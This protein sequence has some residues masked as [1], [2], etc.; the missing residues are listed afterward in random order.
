MAV[1]HEEARAAEAG[2]WKELYQQ[3]RRRLAMLWKAFEDAEA[4]IASLERQ[5]AERA[6]QVIEVPSREPA[7]APAEEGLQPQPRYPIAVDK[8]AKVPGIGKGDLEKLRTYGVN[9]TD[10]LLHADL[11]RLA[12]ATGIPPER[13][14]TWRDT[15]ELIALKGLGPTWAARLVDA[16]VTSIPQ[17]AAMTPEELQDV[18]LK[19]YEQQGASED[20]MVLMRRTL[21]SRCRALVEAARKAARAL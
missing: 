6:P 9:L 5:L 16:G 3:E 12:E 4:R 8:L 13:L 17:L 20:K 21:P 14:Q 1:T 7:E 15:C 18:L 2:T 19:G 10:Q 11:P